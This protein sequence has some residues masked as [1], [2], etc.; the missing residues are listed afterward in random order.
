MRHRIAAA[1]VAG[2]I[3]ACA[4]LGLDTVRPEPPSARAI[5]PLKAE[6]PLSGLVLG[7][8]GARGFAHVGIIKALEAAG[9]KPD[10]VVGA[11]SGAIVA[12]LYAAGYSGSELEQ[13]ATDLQETAL[14][15]FALFGQGWLRGNALQAFVND[16]VDN[17]PIERLPKAFAVVATNAK[18]GGPYRRARRGRCA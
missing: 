15:D 3:S 14:I 2:V 12:A 17:R 8:G 1:L 4:P 9:I 16:A 10:I 13:L 5:V 6:R 11:S 18:S 7:G